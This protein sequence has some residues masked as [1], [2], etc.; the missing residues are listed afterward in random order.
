MT[1]A[2][3]VKTLL[4]TIENKRYH[5]LH[6]RNALMV[7]NK[8]AKK[9]GPLSV[10]NK[11]LADEYAVE[12]LGSRR[13]APWLYVYTVWAGEFKE[14]WI[15]DNY[16]GGIVVPQLQ[17]EYGK[18][19]F[20][21]MMG[22]T[23]YNTELFPDI[24]YFVNGKWL[25]KDLQLVPE[26]DIEGLIFDAYDEVVFKLDNSLKGRGIYLFDKS[27]F[28]IARIISLGNGVFQYRVQQHPFFDIFS[29]GA[30]ATVRITTVIDQANEVS[31]RSSFLRLGR[32]GQT[33]VNSN[34]LVSVPIDTETGILGT[35]GNLQDW[36]VTTVHP[37]SGQ[38]FQGKR[39]P[40][41]EKMVQLGL[42]L[43]KKTPY[44]GAIGW[45]IAI[46]QNE[47]LHMLEWNGY[48]NDIKY[49]EMTQGPCFTD[50]GWE[51]LWK[52]K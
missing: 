44:I 52:K 22:N 37:D 19:S 7:Q 27:S 17:G 35:E 20:G 18:I 23:F 15:P 31:F 30:L 25:S 26:S 21:N 48:H 8:I 41:F 4:K 12:V 50:L 49:G 42:T 14:G 28:D 36:S 10:K 45:D 39:I 11:K 51:K 1:T 2:K 40:Q 6:K 47:Q 16:Y 29:S 43:H 13:Y 34:S 24:G 5:F 38:P 46:D 3:T 33:H 9:K 32:S